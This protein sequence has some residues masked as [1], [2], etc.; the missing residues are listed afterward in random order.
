MD[1]D[2]AEKIWK[3][4]IIL[5]INK[6]NRYSTGWGN[7]FKVFMM[8]QVN[9]IFYNMINYFWQFFLLVVVS[10]STKEKTDIFLFRLPIFTVLK[11]TKL[12]WSLKIYIC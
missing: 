10:V 4:L 12:S 11:N 3:G 8:T 6:I 5:D 1:L 2:W 7:K 9:R